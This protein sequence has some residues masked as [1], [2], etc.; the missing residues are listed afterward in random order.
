MDSLQVNN[1]NMINNLQPGLY[2]I[3][4]E[5]DNGAKQQTVIIKEN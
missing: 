4:K 1:P 2:N 3:E 5:Y